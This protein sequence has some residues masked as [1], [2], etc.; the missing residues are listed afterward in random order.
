MN[1]ILTCRETGYQTTGE[2]KCK[3]SDNYIVRM[4]DGTDA[5]FAMKDWE[6]EEVQS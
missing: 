6:C 4:Q 3:T 2:L 5:L 1:V